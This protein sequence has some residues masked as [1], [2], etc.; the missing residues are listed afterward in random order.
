DP[1]SPLAG[2][3][4]LRHV[5]I[6]GHSIGGATAVQ[7]MVSEPRFRVGVDLGGKLFGTEPDARLGRSFLWIQ[8][9]DTK[10]AEYAN[11]RNRFFAH[12]SGRATLLTIGKSMHRSFSESPSD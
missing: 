5:G 8:S 6:V 11:G 12:Q 7:V 10:T 3:L 2:H 4:D 9:G 1:G